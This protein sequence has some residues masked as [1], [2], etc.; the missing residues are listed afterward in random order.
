MLEATTYTSSSTH[1]ALGRVL[2]AISPDSSEVAYTYNERGALK[3]VD[4]KHR[5]SA[6]STPV[7]S[8]IHYD[9]R[10]RRAQPLARHAVNRG[11]GHFL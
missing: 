7:V 3:T 10:G 6:T 1:D 5:G 11:G 8:D 2:T 9:V 4:C